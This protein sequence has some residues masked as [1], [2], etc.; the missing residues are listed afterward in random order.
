M[1]ICFLLLRIFNVIG[2]ECLRI[3]NVIG[4]EHGFI[5]SVSLNMVEI[6]MHYT[7]TFHCLITQILLVDKGAMKRAKNLRT[8]FATLKDRFITK[9]FFSLALGV[10]NLA[11]NDFCSVNSNS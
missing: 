7:I 9:K 3:F 4:N 11:L 1:M 2:N 5:P 10:S 8:D 6:K